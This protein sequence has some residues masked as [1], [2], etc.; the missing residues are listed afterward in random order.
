MQRVNK[1]TEG[2]KKNRVSKVIQKKKLRI[3]EETQKEKKRRVSEV[4]QK[5]N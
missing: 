4:V 2:E 5:K 3:N 1:E